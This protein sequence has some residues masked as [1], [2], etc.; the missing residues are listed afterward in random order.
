MKDLMDA[1]AGIVV[2]ILGMLWAFGGL[3]GSIYWAMN[4]YLLGVVLSLFIPGYG[5]VSV[6]LD[7][8]FT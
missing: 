2:F 1:A 6:L 7:V 8:F 3:I 5:A 4:D